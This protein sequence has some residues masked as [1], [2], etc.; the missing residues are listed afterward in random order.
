MAASRPFDAKNVPATIGDAATVAPVAAMPHALRVIT[1][2]H[3]FLVPNARPDLTS[4][5][6]TLRM[7]E[8]G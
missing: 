3:D 2:G 1:A 8:A 4:D 7:L 5:V 6:R